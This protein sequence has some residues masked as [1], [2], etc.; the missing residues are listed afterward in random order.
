MDSH[1]RLTSP[2]FPPEERRGGDR[3]PCC[4]PSLQFPLLVVTG[5]QLSLDERVSKRIG[6]EGKSIG[7]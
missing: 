6:S 3:G 4:L 2:F 7:P 5:G 1:T